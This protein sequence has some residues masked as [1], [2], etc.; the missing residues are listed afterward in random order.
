MSTAT[1]PI[2]V[3]QVREAAERLAPWVH[4]TPVLTSRTFDARCGG[5]VFFK[6][7]NFQKVG[8]F[9]FRGAM[10]ALLQLDD[11]SRAAGVVTHSSGN[12]GQALAAAGQQLG[13]QVCV[14]MPRTAPAVKRAAV[15]GY[16][17]RV[18]ECEPTLS[19]REAAV[20]DEISSR[21]LHLV[22]P[23]DDWRVVAGQGTA[24]W[25][26]L[27]QAGPL[28]VVVCPVGGG[29]L[30]SGTVLAVKGRSPQ[31]KVFGAE[32]ERADDARRSLASGRIEPSNDPKTVSDGLRTSLGE[33]TFAVL[34]DG[35]D[36]VFT[37]TEAGTLDA[38]RFVWERLKI[39][40]EPS[41]AVPVAPVLFGD[42]DVKGLRV[43][44]ILS[45]GNVDVAPMFEALAAKWL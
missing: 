11:A 39:V 15:E 3:E 35:L 36:G 13:I 25:E 44:I 26:L 42:L 20:A 31:T 5:S 32:P 21:G 38:M 40:I 37:A 18:V 24:A 34:R 9:K 33:K 6:C 28:D 2:G 45:G 4:R 17:A 27:D 1:L 16:G 41:T 29:G 8:A 14:V 22:H 30:A 10:N 19:A 23:F 43:G 12:H 7:E